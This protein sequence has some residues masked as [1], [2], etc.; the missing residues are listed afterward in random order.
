MRLR[1]LSK[2]AT[3]VAV[4]T[5]ML[6]VAGIAFAAWTATGSGSGTASSLTAQTVTVNAATG[7]AD[8]FPGGNGAVFFTLTNTNP[9]SITFTSAAVGAITSS[10]TAACPSAN[11]VTGPG[12][13]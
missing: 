6:M 5:G 8:L 10:D 12:P 3:V 13:R 2:K 7:P 11:V 4:F 9:Y 1:K